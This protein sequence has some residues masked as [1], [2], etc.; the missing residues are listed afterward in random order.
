MDADGEGP[1]LRVHGSLSPAACVSP[2]SCLISLF[3]PCLLPTSPPNEQHARAPSFSPVLL[4]AGVHLALPPFPDL[5]TARSCPVAAASDCCRVCWA[6]T[7]HHRSGPRAGTWAP[8]PVRGCS[9]LRE[10]EPSCSMRGGC[11]RVGLESSWERGAKGHQASCWL[12]RD[13]QPL[14]RAGHQALEVRDVGPLLAL[15]SSASCWPPFSLME[16]PP[17]SDETVCAPRV[18]L[19]PPGT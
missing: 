16:C 9:C 13:L 12:C 3:F 17:Q 8:A 4:P 6:G 19:A 14:P 15:S 1:Q 10:V 7:P 5:S 2:C 11:S 18:N